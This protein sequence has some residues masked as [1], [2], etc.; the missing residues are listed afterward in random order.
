M[1]NTE[2]LQESSL[3]LSSKLLKRLGERLVLD[4]L[5]SE[6]QLQEGLDRQRSTG[7]FLGEALISLGFITPGQ[8]GPYM[9]EVSGF[10]FFDYGD[11]RIDPEVATLL[12]EVVCRSK[13]VIPFRESAGRVHVAMVDPLNLTVVDEIRASL[14]R[15]IVPYLAFFRDVD[16]AIRKTYDGRQKAHALIEEMLDGAAAP[17]ESVEVLVGQ[18]EDAP[19]VRLVTSIVHGA[20]SAGASD[21]HLEPQ[22]SDVRVRYRI[23]GL[24]YEQMTFPAH[25]HA[26]VM[27]RLKIISA[28]D[29]AER[30]R[31]QDGRFATRTDGAQDFDVRLSIMPTV[32]GEKAC[33]RLLEKKSSLGS[34]E[35]LGLSP[36][37]R[38]I[39]ERLI[40][41]PHGIILVTGPTGSGKSTTLYAALQCIN[42]PNININT[43][44]DPVEFKLAGVNQMQV[45]HRIGVTFAAGLRTLVRQDPDVILVGEIRDSET[46]EIAV[47]AALT[48]HLV[49]STL[50]TNDAPGALVRLQNMGVEPFLLS[51]AVVGV[52][53]QRLLRTTCLGCRENEP[54]EDAIAISLGLPMRHEP[55]TIARGKGCRRCGGRG[56]M[57]RTGVYEIMQMNDELRNLLFRNASG[58]EFHE[59][60]SRTGMT[61]MR[62]SAIKKMLDLVVTPEEVMRVLSYE[63]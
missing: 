51:S 17:T 40:K 56:T 30:R 16:Q 31:P 49:L 27:S 24:L 15:P 62:E 19:V 58:S 59:A 8:I 22:E 33:M 7:E 45:N 57:G 32:Y 50:H 14:G 61:T 3:R 34:V 25:Y 63:G 35:R 29:I 13:L 23:D 1:E 55:Y 53:G 39:F 6:S 52:V 47:Q 38:A 60:A 44:E 28:L 26:A 46:A 21:I 12:S 10:P 36:E 4:G 9:E 18:A 37:Q 43:I 42:E 11:A 48:G 20:I 41:K 2:A 54:L 5:V